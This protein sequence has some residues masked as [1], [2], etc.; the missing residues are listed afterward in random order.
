[1]GVLGVRQVVDRVSLEV[2]S[3]IC[4]F[5]LSSKDPKVANR[6]SATGP[7]VFLVGLVL[8]FLLL[9]QMSGHVLSRRKGIGGKVWRDSEDSEAYRLFDT[10]SPR[11]E[12]QE[13]RTGMLQDGL[14]NMTVGTGCTHTGRC[15]RP[16]GRG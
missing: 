14:S 13:Q 2:F 12:G 10:G 5:S 11:V 9:L 1:M 7:E 4:L 6:C 3:V 15:R 8:V 16:N